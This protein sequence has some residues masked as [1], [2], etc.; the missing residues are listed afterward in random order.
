MDPQLRHDPPPTYQSPFARPDAPQSPPPPQDPLPPSRQASS[1]R[2]DSRSRLNPDPY[3][4]SRADGDSFLQPMD[5]QPGPQ[6]PPPG[7][8]SPSLPPMPR[9]ILRSRPNHSPRPAVRPPRTQI[10]V[11][12]FQPQAFRAYPTPPED[13]PPPLTPVPASG[14]NVLQRERVGV[15]NDR[16]AAER[17]AYARS[18]EERTRLLSNTFVRVQGSVW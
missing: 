6:D 8:Q 13:S 10:P 18:T 2:R 17:Y 9:S 3:T 14:D 1:P 5:P 12:Y 11:R 16:A 15:R 4:R 7:Y